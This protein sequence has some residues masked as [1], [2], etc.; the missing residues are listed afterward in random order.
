MTGVADT[1][2]VTSIDA[3]VLEESGEGR[4]NRDYLRI[5]HGAVEATDRLLEAWSGRHTV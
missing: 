3:Y 1:G 2:T 5:V 4:V